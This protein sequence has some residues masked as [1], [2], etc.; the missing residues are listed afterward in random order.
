MAIALN[1]PNN[2]LLNRW[3]LEM[4]EEPYTFNQAQG[5]GA[6]LNSGCEP[7]IQRD[8]EV[9]ASALHEAILRFTDVINFWPQPEWFS[10]TIPLG[11]STPYWRQE[12]RMRKSFKL[13]DLGKR[14][15]ALIQAGAAVVYSDPSNIGVN[16][17]A[18]ITIADP[19]YSTDEI[20]IFFQTTDQIRNKPGGAGDTHYQIEPVTVTISGGNLIITGH[21]SLF[22]SPIN[23]WGVPYDATDPNLKEINAALTTNALANATEFVTAV[24]IYRVYNDTTDNIEVLAKDNTVLATFSGLIVD[25][26]SSIV[27]IQG[28]CADF[29]SSLA[30]SCWPVKIRVN[31]R[32]GE[33]LSNG[34]MDTELAEAIIRLANCVMRE[35]LVRTCW[36]PFDAWS[37][38]RLP[39][40]Q[41]GASLLMPSEVKNRFG[42][43]RGEIHAWRVAYSVIEVKGG[44]ATSNRR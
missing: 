30:L 27:G 28:D 12:F 7:Y 33:P 4:G 41:D 37:Q 36:R 8:R 35:P 11:R 34:Q 31:Y 15:A 14:T 3:Q 10:E 16:D 13:I 44:K 26:D 5:K 40:I 22:V 42:I 1:V 19:G 2:R 29:C 32:A 23:I 6:P 21:A 25:A 9:I 24:D 43:R 38:D 39:M 17:T 20:Q 18:T